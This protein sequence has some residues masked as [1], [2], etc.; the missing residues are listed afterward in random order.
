MDLVL[1][2]RSGRI[3]ETVKRL[4]AHK[5]AKLE[6]ID[7]RVVRVEVELREERNPRVEGHQKVKV[8]ARTARRS[9]RA[10]GAGA[11]ASAA[12]DQV[13]DRLDRQLTRYRS[14]FRARLMAGAGAVKFGR[15]RIPDVVEPVE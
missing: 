1:K 10:S 12:F 2:G 15:R 13:L 3:P 7:P 14:R 6:R 4:A 11:D 9:F 5:L 8:V